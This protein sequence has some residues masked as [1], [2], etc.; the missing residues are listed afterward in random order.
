[1]GSMSL[2]PR[3]FQLY[4]PLIN[5]PSL[6][7]SRNRL[8]RAPSN[9]FAGRPPTLAVGGASRMSTRVPIT[10]RSA[11]NWASM[12]TTAP[13]SCRTTQSD[14]HIDQKCEANH[15]GGIQLGSYRQGGPAGYVLRRQLIA[16]EVLRKSCCHGANRRAS[17]AGA[18][19][20]GFSNNRLDRRVITVT[21]AVMPLKLTQ[22]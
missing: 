16:M 5:A 20:P 11:E 8:P 4:D 13:N 6:F 19:F 18:D 15:G 17:S 9:W 22:P 14:L 1:M 7:P 2:M 12:G 10:S 21:N 3:P